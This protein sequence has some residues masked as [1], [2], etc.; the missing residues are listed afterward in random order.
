M[1]HKIPVGQFKDWNTYVDNLF[2]DEDNWQVICK[3]CHD[4]KT[5]EENDSYDKKRVAKKRRK[6]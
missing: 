5:K 1:D 4:I 2:C 3:P 6:C